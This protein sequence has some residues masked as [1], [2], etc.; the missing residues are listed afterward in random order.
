M[1][2]ADLR[3]DAQALV[4][5]LFARIDAKDIDGAVGLY[6]ADA[7]FLDAK[8]PAAI[9]DVMVR[10]LAPNADHQSRHVITNLRSRPAGGASGSVVVSYTALAFTLAGD[11]PFAARSILD[12]EQV[13]RRR[14]DGALE[15]AAQRIFGYG[16]PG[17]GSPQG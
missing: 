4:V 11:G 10:G 15:I 6:A 3:L 13:I 12:Q 5:E 14:A 8:G 9:R 7:E 17:R 16:S 1:N 2:D